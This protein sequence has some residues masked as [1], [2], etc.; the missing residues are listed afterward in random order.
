MALHLVITYKYSGE[1]TQEDLDYLNDLASMQYV[2]GCH[3]HFRYLPH[4]LE[5]YTQE[6]P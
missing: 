2:E 6:V 4:T 3:E 1:Y 5:I